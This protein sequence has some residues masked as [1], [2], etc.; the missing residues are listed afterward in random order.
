VPIVCFSVL[1]PIV[2][3]IYAEKN[4]SDRCDVW[5]RGDGMECDGM[6]DNQLKQEGI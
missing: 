1:C 5:K 3:Q 6:A 2:W 4:V